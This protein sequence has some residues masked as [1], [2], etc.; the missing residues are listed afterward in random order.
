V[1]SEF[2][3]ANA[4]SYEDEDTDNS[5]WIEIYNGQNAS[6]NL[7]GWTLTNLGSNKTLWTFPSVIIGPYQ[8]RVIF[9]SGKNRVNAS[10]PLHTNFT[11]QRES[12]Y[13]ALVKPDGTTVAT[14]FTYGEQAEDVSFGEK[15]T[16]RTVGY[17]YPPTPG[18]ANTGNIG[19]GPP[20]EDVVFSREGG[21]ITGQ[22][23]L[24]ITAPVALGAV[25]R[26]TTNNTEPSATS[27]VYSGP[28]NISATT[29]IRARVFTPGRLPGPVSSRT[30]LRVDT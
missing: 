22:V 10:L 16:A 2:V 15:G 25:V 11:L 14:E 1:I 21:L 5:D 6:V 7:S 8:Y 9:A 17:L 27:P 18:S 3:A 24:G 4:N 12:G 28:F 23:T 26:Y 19:D 29:T 13:L 30:M 20:A